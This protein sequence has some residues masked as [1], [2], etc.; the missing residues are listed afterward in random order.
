M[1]R[2]VESIPPVT[3]FPDVF[4]APPK[5][6]PKPNEL[7]IGIEV[8]WAVALLTA[9]YLVQLEPPSLN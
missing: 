4:C 9:P 6:Y 7:E 2:K 8:F 1:F 5:P 3:T